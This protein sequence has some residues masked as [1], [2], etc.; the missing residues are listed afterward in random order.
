MTACAHSLDKLLL[1]FDSVL[2]IKTWLLRCACPGRFCVYLGKWS[3]KHTK[4]N[5]GDRCCAEG[6][7]QEL[8]E[9]EG[10][11]LASQISGTHPKAWHIAASQ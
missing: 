6:V 4:C 7:S 5:P 8:W 10:S 3:W 2:G 9:W 11:S 1:G